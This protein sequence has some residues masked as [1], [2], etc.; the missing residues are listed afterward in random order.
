MSNSCQADGRRMV[1]PNGRPNATCV[2]CYYRW[3]DSAIALDSS[4]SASL[5]SRP[6]WSGPCWPATIG[7]GGSWAVQRSVWSTRGV[8]L[9][10]IWPV[11]PSPGDVMSTN[12]SAFH[13]A[14]D[15]GDVR[16]AMSGL[17]TTPGAYRL[18]A[19]FYGRPTCRVMKDVILPDI[20]YF[21]F[22]VEERCGMFRRSPMPSTSIPS[23]RRA[24]ARKSATV[25][26]EAERDG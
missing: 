1:L 22:Q 7:L 6:R 23:C 14:T 15:L 9:R 3:P 26:G 11:Q 21:H 20:K 19:L 18:V 16:T 25:S 17:L 24:G 10:A 5:L 2:E 12:F 4:K 8:G 13:G